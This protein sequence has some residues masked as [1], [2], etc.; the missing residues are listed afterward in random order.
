MEKVDATIN[1]KSMDELKEAEPCRCREKGVLTC[2]DKGASI[3]PSMEPE[4]K[5]R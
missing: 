5:N 2:A 4:T 1:I 3:Q